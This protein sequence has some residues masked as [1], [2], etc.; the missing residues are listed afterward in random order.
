M[1][2]LGFCVG[3]CFGAAGTLLLTSPPPLFEMN[4]LFSLGADQ[5]IHIR[6]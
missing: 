3:L 5:N 6:A 4:F 2:S 1:L